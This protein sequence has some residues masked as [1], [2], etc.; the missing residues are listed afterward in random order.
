MGKSKRD[1]Q[2]STILSTRRENSD[3]QLLPNL[4]KNRAQQQRMLRMHNKRRS[5]KRF[6]NIRVR[7]AV[8]LFREKALQSL[9]NLGKAKQNKRGGVIKHTQRNL[10]YNFFLTPN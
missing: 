10:Y 3:K 1:D 2:T 4:Q 5:G 6:G 7:S 9:Q 8:R